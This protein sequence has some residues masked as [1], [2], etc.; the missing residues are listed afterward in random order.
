M[1]RSMLE[2][3]IVSSARDEHRDDSSECGGAGRRH[4]DL[5]RALEL[6][7]KQVVQ[8]CLWVV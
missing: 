3:D 6:Q 5:Q 1:P 4:D 7:V 8:L 2:R